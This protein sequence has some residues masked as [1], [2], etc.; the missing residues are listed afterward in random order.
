M[1]IADILSSRSWA[2]PGGAER[3][4]YVPLA[5]AVPEAPSWMVGAPANDPRDRPVEDEMRAAA[6]EMP[7]L[8]LLAPRSHRELGKLMGRAAASVNT[9]L[10][11]GM[12]NV[13][14]EAWSRG[15]HGLVLQHDPSGVM[16]KYRLGGF[17]GGLADRL[18]ELACEQW[19]LQHDR[20]GVARRCRDDIAAH[21]S[22]ESAA[23]RWLKLLAADGQG[24]RLVESNPVEATC[25]G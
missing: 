12:P 19:R 15:V 14:L 20:S 1:F 17:A 4:K 18:A 5:R 23:E 22:P 7:N 16:S 21:H 10:F 13:F 8:E 11:E 3:Q 24:A 2:L 25:A 6:R 9:A